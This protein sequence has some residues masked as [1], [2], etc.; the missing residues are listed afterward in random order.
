MTNEI[1]Q[2]NIGEGVIAFSTTRKGGVST[3]TYSAF[4]IT[5]YCGDNPKCVKQNRETLCRFLGITDESLFLPRQT[6]DTKVLC[7]DDSFL[8]LSSEE[9]IMQLDGIDA[10]ITNI[11]NI[12]IGVSTADCVPI[13][14]FD[15]KK[16]VVAAV[17]AGWRGTV[18]RILERTIA[19][20]MDSYNTDP[21]DI[22]AVIAPSISL[23]SFEV[24]DEVY[25]VFAT[26]GFAMDNIAKRYGE[27]WHIDLWEANCI[28]LLSYGVLSSSI[29][30]SGICTYK[31]YDRFFSARRL[32]INSGR[33]F[34]GIMLKN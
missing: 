17:H 14:L 7:I 31:E 3:G 8:L 25:D 20:M 21:K 10:V 29:T 11:P 33:I 34:N 28:Q 18:A 16:R 26:N 15:R 1:L 19:Q 12:C 22:S 23:D 24:G 5:H 27:R 13:L 32:G 2:Y 4:N 6:H 30:V 9:R